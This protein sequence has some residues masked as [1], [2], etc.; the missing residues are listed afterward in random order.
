MLTSKDLALLGLLYQPWNLSPW[1]LTN[2]CR[3]RTCTV[4]TWVS[5][6]NGVLSLCVPEIMAILPSPGLRD[7]NAE[8]EVREGV[9]VEQCGHVCPQGKEDWLNVMIKCESTLLSHA[10]ILHLSPPSSQTR[11]TPLAVTFGSSPFYL[12]D[13]E[14]TLY[15]L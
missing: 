2:R 11:G 1:F 5:I 12:T 6:V 9:S 14:P 8:W 4:R 13:S 3:N 15:P 7:L 10:A